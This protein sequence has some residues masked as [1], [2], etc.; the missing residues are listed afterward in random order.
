MAYKVA[1]AAAQAAWECRWAREGR[2]LRPDPNVGHPEDLW[3]C[4]RPTVR[5]DRRV[6]TEA[7]CTGCEHWAVGDDDAR[8]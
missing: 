1:T 8:R 6:V 7:E 5:G 4:V 2:R 3:I